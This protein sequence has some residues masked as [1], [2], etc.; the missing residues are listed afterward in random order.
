MSGFGMAP[1]EVRVVVF[2]LDDTLYPE[3]EFVKSGFHAVASFLKE[4]GKV[5][6]DLYGRMWQ[7]FCSGS[8]RTIFNEMFADAGMADDME[9][10]RKSVDVFRYHQ[11]AICLSPDAWPVLEFFRARKKLCLLTDGYLRMQ[12]NK[13]RAL[14][15]E[16]FFDI[17]VFTDELGG[18]E[19]WKPHP[20]GYEKIM[21]SFNVSGSGCAYIGD[22]PNKDF[23]SARR[24]GWKTVRIER[25]EGIYSM[26]E[27]PGAG[28]EAEITITDLGDLETIIK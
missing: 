15:I 2:D 1:E 27:A 19:F 9:L 7:K 21:N 3:I 25:P 11:P 10:I 18:P 16:H 17:I 20:A 12:K 26:V 4:T 28:Y 14:E 5:S 13:V 6:E 23:L 24:L 22:N 8:R